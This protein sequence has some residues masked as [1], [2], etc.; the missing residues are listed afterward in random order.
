MRRVTLPRFATAAAVCV[1]ALA[2]IAHGQNQ[3]MSLRDAPRGAG[4]TVQATVA[5]LDAL[6]DWDRRI[7]RMRRDA[8]SHAEEAAPPSAG[9]GLLLSDS[10][11]A[12]VI[13]A[14]SGAEE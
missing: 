2:P 6:R 1:A 11:V 4:T 5:G 9:A 12:T 7:D 13:D 8:E 3:T 10:E 14:R